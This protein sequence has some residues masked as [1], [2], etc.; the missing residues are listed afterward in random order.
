MINLRYLYFSL[1]LL[2]VAVHPGFGQAKNKTLIV[3]FDGLRPDY[4]TAEQ[5]PNLFGFSKKASRGNHHHSVFPTV[6]RVNSASYATGSYPGTHGLLGNSVYFPQIVSNKA[7]GTGIGDLTK[8]SNSTSGKLLTAV[9]LGEVLQTAGERMFVYS[10]GTTGQAF[11][12]NHKVGKGAIINPDLVLPETL[13]AEIIR[14]AGPIPADDETHGHL[15][16]RW[17]TDALLKYTL[18]DNGPLVSAIWYSD[19]DGAAHEHGMGSDEAV[20]SIRYVDGQFGRILESLKNKGLEDKFNIII[21]TDHGFV[22]HVGKQSVTDFL[23]K[24]GFKKDKESDDVVIAEGALYVKNHDREVI[25]KIVSALQAEEWIGAVFTK[26]AKPGNDKGWVPGTISFDAIHYHHPERSGDILV[27]MNWDDRRNEKGFAGTDYS[28]GVA[29]HGG[30]S[31]YEINIAMFVAGPDFK[32]GLSN[33]LPTSNV[34]ITPTI[35]SVY[36][37]PKPASMDGRAI[38]EFLRTDKSGTKK[39]GK[40]RWIKTSV[41]YDWGK[42]ELQLEQTILGNYKYVNATRVTRTLKK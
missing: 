1:W 17:I 7:I 29:G 14:E 37:L 21:S 30:S 31:P 35:L 27:A 3:F 40:K 15:R 8:I 10:S 12:Q 34:D 16:H 19:P 33:E 13:K 4:I 39:E 32:E 18:D 41:N 42:Y 23:I 36:H 9:S 2:A 26:S 22:T 6:T 38:T 28:G 5:M 25:Q 20:K 24:K 11:L